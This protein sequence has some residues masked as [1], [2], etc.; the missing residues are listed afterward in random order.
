MINGGKK[1]RAIA[2][3]VIAAVLVAVA[4]LLLQFSY[5]PNTG[6]D[7]YDNEAAFEAYVAG[8]GLASLPSTMRG[9]ACSSRD[10]TASRWPQAM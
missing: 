9:V 10:S 3:I 7:I 5:V 6:R 1:S 4:G 8:L 2:A